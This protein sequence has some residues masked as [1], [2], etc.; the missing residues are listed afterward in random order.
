ML[1]RSPER[2]VFVGSRRTGAVGDRLEHRS[3]SELRLCDDWLGLE[4]LFEFGREVLVWQ[5]PIF[6]QEMTLAGEFEQKYQSTLIMP[7][8]DLDLPHGRS[9]RIAYSVTLRER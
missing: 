9:R 7:L 1:F 6:S 8:W 2:G 3:P 5:H 4:V